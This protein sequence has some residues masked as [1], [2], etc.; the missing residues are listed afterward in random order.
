MVA[1]RQLYQDQDSLT[2]LVISP[3]PALAAT[4]TATL[5]TPPARPGAL[6]RFQ[7]QHAADLAAATTQARCLTVDLLLLH[8]VADLADPLTALAFWRAN[9]AHVGMGVIVEAGQEPLGQTAVT[10]GACDYLRRADLDSPLLGR[11]LHDWYRQHRRETTVPALPPWQAKLPLV[12]QL[13]LDRA[14]DAI[15]EQI[16]HIIPYDTATIQLLKGSTLQVVR[17][18]TPDAAIDLPALKNRSASLTFEVNKF[19]NLRQIIETQRP[20]VITDTAVFPGWIRLHDEPPLIQSWVGAPLLDEGRLIGIV[21]LD[22]RQSGF[23]QPNHGAQ[24]AVLANQTTLALR[25]ARLYEEARRQMEELQVLHTV[26]SACTDV[27]NL[28]DLYAQ[29]TAIIAKTLYTDNFGILLFDEAGNLYPHP[30]YHI[31]LS[32]S[33]PIFVPRGQGIVGWVA[34]HGRSRYV[35]DVS[36]DPDYLA[37]D[38]HTASELCVPLKIRQ[39]TIGVI[40]AESIHRDGFSAADERLLG[41]LAQQLAIILEKIRLLSAERQR[42]KEAEILRDTMAALT[43]NL[44]LSYVLDQILVQLEKV[45]PHDTSSLILQEKEMLCIRAV[46]GFPNPGELI[47]RCFPTTDPFLVEVQQTHQPIY[48]PDASANPDFQSWGT[49]QKIRGWIC[50]PL[51]VHGRVLGVLTVD[52]HRY[53]AYGPVDIELAQAFANQAAIAIENARLYAAEQAAHQTADLLRTTNEALS[54]TLNTD[55]VLRTL[56]QHLIPV[57]HVD[58]AC[59]LLP[60]E[61]GEL[62]HL[63]STYG[64]EQWTDVTAV[65]Q[66]RLNF[67]TNKTLEPIF[68][69]QQSMLIADTAVHPDW[70]KLPVT[71][72]VRSWMGIPIVVEGQVIGAFSLDKAAPHF[73]TA[74]H[75]NLAEMVTAQAGVAL[76]NAQLFAEVKRQARELEAITKISAALRLAESVDEMLPIVL[77]RTTAVVGGVFGLVYLVEPETGDLVAR[78]SWPHEP[79]V[80]GHRHHVGEGITGYVAEQSKPYISLNVYEDPLFVPFPLTQTPVT[81]LGATISMPLQTQDQVIGVLHVSISETREFSKEEINLLTAV[82][83]IAASALAR[84]ILMATLEQ[85]VARRTQELANANEQLQELDRLKSKFVSD[86]SHELRTPI[87]NLTLYLD[88]LDRGHPERRSQ[89]QT[90][91]RKQ[92]ERLNSLIEDTLQLSRLDMGKTQMQLASQDLN[93]IVAECVTEVRPL[94]EKA[95]GLQITTDYQPALPPIL[96]DKEQ[97]IVVLQNI[98]QNAI[99]YTPQGSIRVATRAEAGGFASVIIADTGTGIAAEELPHVFERF[100]RGTAVSQS[101]LPGTGLGLSIAHEI[102]ERHHGVIQVESQR[103]T[104]STFTISLPVAHEQTPAPG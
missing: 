98:L 21:T 18:R 1:D 38:P 33:Q 50:A 49:A 70:E 20:L 87:T 23:F 92:V 26:A 89:Y 97:I 65:V 76:K 7:V 27:A 28:D 77:A 40:N 15:L 90:I 19:A 61:R 45:V 58:S 55:D 71:A 82:S 59:I 14:L 104:G 79:T 32:V 48:L 51:I 54:R 88:L 44:E 56:L 8:L 81:T 102:I 29:T 96:G 52:N 5:A 60:D 69:H 12:S 43:A 6:P 72:Y 31:R 35:P 100:Y 99:A 39:Q 47:G 24:L 36:R 63:H 13:D 42:R 11:A 75:L 9:L 68:V 64:Y 101:T 73:F 80:I 85:R 46:H 25:N 93:A 22:S 95:G 17:L 74:D 57:L 53:D 4:L 103:G 16:A 67:R 91:L 84:A 62:V 66:S 3:E 10:A 94:A 30:S 78:A 83:E 37:I 34:Q 41:I 86:V 2:V